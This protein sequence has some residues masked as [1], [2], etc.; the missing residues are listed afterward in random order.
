MYEASFTGSRTVIRKV[1]MSVAAQQAEQMELD[2]AAMQ[3]QARLE[4][5]IEEMKQRRYLHIPAAPGCTE[6]LDEDLNEYSQGQYAKTQEL[7]E[8]KLDAIR[9]PANYT[10]VW[11]LTHEFENELE[12]KAMKVIEVSQRVM[13]GYHEKLWVL[14]AVE[15]FME[16]QNYLMDW[17]A[18]VG[19]DMSQK[20][21]VHFV[22]E[23]S[24]SSISVTL[25]DEATAGNV[26]KM[27]MEVLTFYSNGN[28]VSEEEKAQL[29]KE[30]NL[31]LQKAGVM[32]SISCQGNKHQ[33]SSKPQLDTEDGV[34]S[35]PVKKIL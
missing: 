14:D 16:G 28:P 8:E 15:E 29:R 30:L 21:V 12:P 19:D 1:A 10:A 32:G 13:Q 23:K 18:P 26:A 2:F 25:D 7:L 17:A 35:E 3:L 5:L 4:G 20:L 22:N 6:D 11:V 34:L 9:N 33:P 31:A 27:A 24:K